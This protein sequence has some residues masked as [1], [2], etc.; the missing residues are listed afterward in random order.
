M[1]NELYRMI[2][3][4]RSDKYDFRTINEKN[5]Y[6]RDSNVVRSAFGRDIFPTCDFR[7]AWSNATIR[8]SGGSLCCFGCGIS[9]RTRAGIYLTTVNDINNARYCGTLIVVVRRASAMHAGSS[10]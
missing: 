1:R 7:E 9:H 2:L 5:C 3:D 6:C 8:K 10:A 4:T